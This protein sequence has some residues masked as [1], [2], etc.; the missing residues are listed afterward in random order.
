MKSLNKA[1]SVSSAAILAWLAAVNT[2][3]AGVITFEDVSFEGEWMATP[4]ADGVNDWYAGDGSIGNLSFTSSYGGYAWEGFKASKATDAS[5]V[6]YQNDC[7]SNPGGGAGGSQKYAVFY[8]M[9][10]TSYGTSAATIMFSEAVELVSMDV[11]NTAY[12][13]YSIENGDGYASAFADVEGEVYFNLLLRGVDIDGNYSEYLKISLASKG[14][15]GVVVSLS[16]WSNFSLESLN[17]EG[18]LYGLE[19]SIEGSPNIA[20]SLG[21]LNTPTYAAFDNISYNLAAVPEPAEWAFAFGA[22]A[23]ALALYGRK[24]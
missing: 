15:D 24:R 17:M 10:N 5:D 4:T 13:E 12:V 2:A 20:G 3:N 11:C 8:G 21:Y 1:V 23:L 16:D 19:F 14:S 9:S 6:T 18:G 7:C 22:A